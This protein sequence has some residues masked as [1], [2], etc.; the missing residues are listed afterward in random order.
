MVQEVDHKETR[1][2]MLE[3][4]ARETKRDF[5][6][7]LETYQAAEEELAEAKAVERERVLKF[8]SREKKQKK[9]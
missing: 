7:L 8:R 4:E 2:Q 6:E 3:K 9:L 5:E 1:I